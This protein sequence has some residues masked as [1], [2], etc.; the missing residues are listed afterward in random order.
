MWSRKTLMKYILFQLP[1]TALVLISLFAVSKWAGLPVWSI[2]L[3]LLL[4][5]IKDIALYPLLWRSYSVQ[6]RD[7]VRSLT[8]LTGTVTESLLPDGYII[9]NGEQWRAVSE[10]KNRTIDKGEQVI[11]KAV[12]GLTLTVKPIKDDK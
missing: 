10:D 7:P 8:G 3:A 4:W 1:G 2:W 5:I 6:R 9:V 11:V 12:H